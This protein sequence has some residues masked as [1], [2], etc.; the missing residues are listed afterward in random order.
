MAF[1]FSGEDKMTTD[2]TK[3]LDTSILTNAGIIAT[4]YAGTLYTTWFNMLV[5]T[6]NT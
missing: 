4:N 6:D 1:N 3:Y 2:A 5:W